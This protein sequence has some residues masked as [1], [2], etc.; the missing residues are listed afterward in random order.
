M[1]AI[2][3]DPVDD[4]ELAQM[5]IAT[6]TSVKRLRL[7]E[8][9]KHYQLPHGKSSRFG[10]GNSLGL[11]NHVIDIICNKVEMLQ[12]SYTLKANLP[13]WRDDQAGQE[14]MQGTTCH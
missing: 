12:S 1:K 2:D 7:K 11:T 3:T 13:L 10:S 5:H 8:K 4:E 6:F 14:V 9:L